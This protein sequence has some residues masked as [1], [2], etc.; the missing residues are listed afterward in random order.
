M[1]DKLKKQSSDY[2]H[3]TFKGLVSS[4]PYAGGPLSVLFES[5]FSAPID[6][7]KNEWLLSLDEAIKELTVTVDGLTTESLRTNEIFISVAMQASQ[8]ALRNHQKEKLEALKYAV[9]NSV[10]ITSINENKALIFT[11]VIDELT[12][13]HLQVLSFLNSPEI[14]EKVLQDK[15]GINTSVYYPGNINIWEETYPEMK[16][17][18][19]LIEQIVKELHTKGFVFHNSFHMGKGSVTTNYGKEFLEFIKRQT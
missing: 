10:L 3:A 12:P 18:E 5:V 1:S 11:R 4:I 19:Q 15:A 13:L 7:R 17:E 9:I 16:K 6:K 14:H 2:V 8:I